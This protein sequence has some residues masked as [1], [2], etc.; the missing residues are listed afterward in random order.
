[1][2]QS[3]R[4]FTPR[5]HLSL[6]HSAIQRELSMRKLFA[7]LQ[8]RPLQLYLLGHGSIFVGAWAMA[9]FGS[10]VPM[11]LASSAALM[12]SAPMLRQLLARARRP[13]GESSRL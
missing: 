5:R 9:E 10:M 3:R 11:A 13:R 4:Y 2:A 1:M 8:G 6:Q 7:S 12:L